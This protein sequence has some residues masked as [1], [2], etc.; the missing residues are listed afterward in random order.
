MVVGLRMEDKW[1]L[2]R[3]RKRGIMSMCKSFVVGG[4]IL[5]VGEV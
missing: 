5:V 1:G 3:G 2:K 4:S